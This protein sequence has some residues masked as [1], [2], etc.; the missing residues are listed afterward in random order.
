MATIDDRTPARP[1][2]RLPDLGE[3]LTEAELVR[4]LV[5]PGDAVQVNQP[6]L[7]VETAKAVVEIPSPIAGTV[8]ELAA[9]EGD[10]VVVGARLLSFE[11]PPD[12]GDAAGPRAAVLVGYGPSEQAPGRRRRRSPVPEQASPSSSAPPPVEQRVP[13]K[14][15]VRKLA[16]EL[17]VDLAAVTGSGVGGVV[18]RADVERLATNSAA[19]DA[20]KVETVNNEPAADREGRIPVRGVRRA[21]AEAMVRSVAV[22]QASVRLAVDVTAL[23][24]LRERTRARGDAPPTVLAFV[25]RAA[26][27][28]LGRRPMLHARWE[29]ETREIAVTTEISLGIAVSG[30]RGLLVPKIRRAETRSLANLAGQI[31]RLAAAAR[32]GTCLP[33]DLVGGTFTISNVGVFGVD[34][35]TSLLIPGETAILCVGAVRQ[36]PWVAEGA[37]AVRS[38]VE[39]TLTIDHRTVDGE[40]AAGFLADLG[41]MLEDPLEMLLR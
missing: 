40:Q 3:G 32:G 27:L 31:E 37:L 28:A 30:P 20:A 18:T 41:A 4:W 22:P 19:V 14:P 21:T 12:S 5:A 2:F 36:R 33:T 26:V 16:R 24:D 6:L 11:Q 13:A 9:A 7:E 35:G 23:G 29:E 17:G 15:P 25:A 8:H 1:T 39:L 10:V 38:V 34:A